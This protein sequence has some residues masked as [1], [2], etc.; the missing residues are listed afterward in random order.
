MNLTRHDRLIVFS[1]LAIIGVLALT[2]GIEEGP[3]ICPFALG[4]GIA[5]PG[6][7]MTRAASWM[8]RGD[9]SSAVAYHP[10]V[11]AIALLALGGWIWFLLR[12][13]GRVQ[14]MSNRLLNGVLIATSVA[15]L[16]VWVARLVTGSL[17][18][19]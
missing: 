2:E 1:P 17:P 19:V 16:G 9:F 3:T 13:T 12:K 6:C 18:P 7:G 4:T 11:P 8:L 15:L 5:C 14:Q 10:L